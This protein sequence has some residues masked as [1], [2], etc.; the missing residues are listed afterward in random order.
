MVYFATLDGDLISRGEI[1]EEAD[2][3]TALARFDELH[4]LKPRAGKRSDPSHRTLSDVLRSP[5]LGRDDRAFWPRTSQLR[6]TD[7]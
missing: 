7:R 1:F 6:T 5:R 4:T 2:L 3:D